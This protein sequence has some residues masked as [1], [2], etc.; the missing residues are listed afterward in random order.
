MNRKYRVAIFAFLL[1]AGVSQPSGAQG[2]YVGGGAQIVQLKGDLDFVTTGF[3]PGFSAGYR[4]ND[5]FSIDVQFGVTIHDDSSLFVDDITV[6]DSLLVGG[7]FSFGSDT[8]KPYIVAGFARHN[9]D[10]EF[11]QSIDGNGTFWGVGGDIFLTKN[12][13]LNIS[14]RKSDWDGE[15]TVFKYD[16]TSEIF[17]VAYNFYFSP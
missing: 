1:L 4:L 2:W 7:K 13:V 14:F 3:G 8:F 12:H 5:L 15:D 11:F 16:I 6:H 9:V 17:T 10:F